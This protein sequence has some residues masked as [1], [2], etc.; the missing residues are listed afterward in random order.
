MTIIEEL[1]AAAVGYWAAGWPVVPVCH[2]E[3]DRLVCGRPPPDA[4]SVREWW[5]ER[6]YG[7][8]CHTGIVFDALVV[9]RWLGERVLPAVEHHAP[10]IEV[11]RS[12]EVAWLFLVTPGSPRIT[13][14]PRGAAV[15]LVG[16]GGWINLPPSATRAGSARWVN[17][18]DEPRLPHSLTMQ[19]SVLR[20]LRKPLP[21]R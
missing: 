17:R 10:V 3:G 20:A 21:A 9:P 11:E 16:A 2:P 15:R 7:I 18:P 6:P 8:G 1:R 19:W 13:D 14:L 12:P 4:E 5:S